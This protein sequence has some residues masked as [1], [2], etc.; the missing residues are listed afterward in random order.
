MPIWHLNNVVFGKL[1]CLDYKFVLTTTVIY[2]FL[3]LLLVCVSCIS[4]YCVFILM[5]F[6][7]LCFFLVFFEKAFS[8][9]VIAVEL[10]FIKLFLIYQNFCYIFDLMPQKMYRLM[11]LIQCCLWS[12]GL[13]VSLISHL[14]FLFHLVFL[15]GFL[16]K[17]L[18][19]SSCVTSFYDSSDGFWFSF[20]FIQ[21]CVN[22]SSF[23]SKSSLVLVSI[24]LHSCFQCLSY[25]PSSYL[26]SCSA[27]QFIMS[28]SMF[29]IVW[30]FSCK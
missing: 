24:N 25:F 26:K 15:L 22:N 13:V 9:W 18:C 20:S 23:F 19:I 14:L 5:C 21:F 12:I 30:S 7:L 4:S 6:L 3:V 28:V 11:V 1:K 27:A 17:D 2:H 10:F 16:G 29:L 8:H